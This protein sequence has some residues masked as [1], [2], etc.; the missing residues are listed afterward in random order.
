M[1]FRWPRRRATAL[2]AL[3]VVL[4]A[5]AGCATSDAA[6]AAGGSTGPTAS[7][8]ADALLPAAEGTTQYPLVLDTWAGQT[9]LAE[10]PER[11]AVIGFS[12]NL[13]ALQALDATP[14]Y[15]MGE[16]T[17]WPW[18]DQEWLASIETVDTATREDPISFEAIAASDPDLIVAVNYVADEADF[19]RL[20]SIAPVL[21]NAE[22]VKGDQISWQQTQR[23]IGEALDLSAASEEVIS[24]A[25]A[26]IARTAA[27]HP[28]LAGKTLTAATDYSDTGIAYY[29]V[30][31]GTAER[32]VTQLGFAPNPRAQAFVD[33][34]SVSDERLGELDADV[35]VVFYLDD[36]VRQ[37]REGSPL[38][39]GV[40]AVAD[41]RY[42]SIA[43]GE[44]GSELTWV[45]RRGASALSLP[46][47]VDV[48][49]DRASEV[50]SS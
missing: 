4:L 50:V 20:A 21:E 9:E 11:V 16:E 44:P 2:S 36:A 7:A 6:P 5:L 34:P 25:E 46:W 10:R 3:P 45:M 35:L 41:G 30:A 14:V 33:E 17:E 27:E 49:A 43:T 19:A 13:D 28:E 23:M 42:V 32:V 40:P 12:P 8:A 1:M 37:A 47:A 48:L 31:G 15:T 22:Q 18:R 38:F 29:T 24:G 26:A 39:Q